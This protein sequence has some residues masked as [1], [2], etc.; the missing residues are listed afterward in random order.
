MYREDDAEIIT[1]G[2]EILIGQVVDT[3][4]AW[5]AQELNLR[6]INVRQISSVPDDAVAIVKALLEAE[7][8]A[9]IILITGGLGPT[10]DD[11]TKNTLCNF[12]NGR[13]VTHQGQLE[14]IEKIFASF[15]RPV[16]EVNRR[17]A[18]V[19]DTCTCIVNT[20]GTAPGMW[21]EKGNH[22]FVS[23][24]GVPYEMKAMMEKS[25]LPMLQ[26]RFKFPPLVHRTFLTQG[27]GESMLAGWI[28]EWENSLP[29]Y[30][31]LAYLP[32]PGQVRLRL[33][34]RSV[35]PGRAKAEM[36][37]LAERLY[38]L[39]GRHIFGEGETTLPE[40]IH[41]LMLEKQK[42]LS[43]AES[44]TGGMIAHAL[45]LIPGSST[46]FKG[47]I[48]AYSNEL[49]V[50]VL[51]V[52]EKTIS[53]YGAVSSETA[54]EMAQGALKK[55]RTDFALAVT[56]IAGPDGGSAEKP[57]GTVWLAVAGHQFTETQLLR[58]GQDRSRNIT[59]ASLS[60][61]HL[62]KRMVENR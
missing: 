58:L 47:G 8:R 43:L 28:E 48:V 40:V 31:K 25:I 57:V 44:C 24:P 23:M 56:G 29:D 11:I 33:S 52:S 14:Q 61:L 55:F 19:P 3:N 60:A 62:L 13:L 20:R 21:F 41:H 46:Y 2:D 10:K 49:K 16:T 59:M 39:I 37:E 15:G 53:T 50:S 51:D 34:S 45:T 4:S 38:A 36:Q 17:Q 42:S 32:S 18:D 35:E 6:G 9:S 26:E 1:I 54:I 30:M 27:V 5:M 22:I 7:Q 12:F